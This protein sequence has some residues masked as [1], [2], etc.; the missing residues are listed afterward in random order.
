MGGGLNRGLSE[1]NLR[2]LFV[3]PCFTVKKRM[4]IEEYYTFIL[5][6]F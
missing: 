5:S 1:S 2:V 4:F 3:L 6:I